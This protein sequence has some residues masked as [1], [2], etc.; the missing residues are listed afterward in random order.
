[1]NDIPFVKALCMSRFTLF[2]GNTKDAV[3]VAFIIHSDLPSIH[4]LIYKTRQLTAS[5]FRLAPSNAD[6]VL[7]R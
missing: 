2:L 7:Q 6:R 3:Y 5:P 1:M 4:N